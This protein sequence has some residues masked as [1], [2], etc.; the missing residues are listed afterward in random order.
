VEE[1]EI[2][3]IGFSV[4][5]AKI[6]NMKKDI[7]DFQDRMLAKYSAGKGTEVYFYFTKG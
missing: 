2:S 1:R 3:G 4:D 7:I 5:K 6:P